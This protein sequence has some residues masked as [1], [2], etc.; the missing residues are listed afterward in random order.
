MGFHRDFSEAYES[1][2]I[3]AEQYHSTALAGLGGGN[4]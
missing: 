4:D 1:V 3:V 2:Q